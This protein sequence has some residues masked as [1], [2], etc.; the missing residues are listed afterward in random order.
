LLGTN[1]AVLPGNIKL[2]HH[3]NAPIKL[4]TWNIV[5]GRDGYPVRGLGVI[6][7]PQIGVE[8]IVGEESL[9][10]QGNRLGL[11]EL[12]QSSEGGSQTPDLGIA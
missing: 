8:L 10:Q 9:L 12:L 7:R 1:G 3:F 2:F 5:T 11:P 4:P 6:S